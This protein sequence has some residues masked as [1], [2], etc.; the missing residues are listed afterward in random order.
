MSDRT[1]LVEL[2]EQ[3][4]RLT[5]V[6][7]A[8]QEIPVPTTEGGALWLECPTRAEPRSWFRQLIS[9]DF[10]AAHTRRLLLDP[11]WDAVLAA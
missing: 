5:P 1:H 3:A 4:E 8:C 11:G 6:C 2:I 9:L 10:E 7:A